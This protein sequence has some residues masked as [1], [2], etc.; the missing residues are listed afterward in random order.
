MY[1][2]IYDQSLIKAT[3]K[4]NC[5]ENGINKVLPPID[6]TIIID[7]ILIGLY[8]RVIL[9][10]PHSIYRHIKPNATP[11]LKQKQF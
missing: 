7:H 6:R 4:L 10:T 2:S 5:F 9:S 8:K 1:K 11:T 3:S